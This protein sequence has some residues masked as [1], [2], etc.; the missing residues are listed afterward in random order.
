MM[1][2]GRR[3]PTTENRSS[4]QQALP[5]DDATSSLICGSSPNR[6]HSSKGIT[7]FDNNE[8]SLN[9]ASLNEASLVA[10]QQSAHGCPEKRKQTEQDHHDDTVAETTPP[11]IHE[12]FE[13]QIVRSKKRKKSVSAQ[14]VNGVV[15]VI[16][17]TWMSAS[18]VE[19]YAQNM[20]GRFER[21]RARSDIDLIV[22]AQGLSKKYHFP[23]PASVRW[24][25]NQNSRWGSCTPVDG[26]IRLSDRLLKTPDWVIDYVLIHELGHLLH[27]D[28]SPAF[29]EAVG[30]YPKNDLAR[31]FLL[32]M[33][34]SEQS[35]GLPDDANNEC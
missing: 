34:Y 10:Q 33:G 35:A 26:S 21:K 17:P 12:P 20:L 11:K 28:H 18:E 32:G 9:E 4:D 31:G 3:Q 29:W 23:E 6:F 1:T 15:E 5:F 27:P 22:R 30:V 13:Y 8:A 24:V 25:S 16:V 7:N 19:R 14:M 2:L